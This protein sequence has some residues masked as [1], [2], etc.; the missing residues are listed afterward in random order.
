[1]V[2]IEGPDGAGKST[3]VKWL[4]EQ[5]DRSF[6]A[7]WNVPPRSRKQLER[8]LRAS[9]LLMKCG[10]KII[11]DRSPWVT[12]PIYGALK[13]GPYRTRTWSRYRAQL[14]SSQPIIVY[15]RPPKEVIKEHATTGSS[16]LDTPEYLNWIGDNIDTLI[17]LYDL[18]FESLQAFNYDWTKLDPASKSNLLQLIRNRGGER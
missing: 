16:P 4:G 11:Q 12:E 10:K 13:Q 2:I 5:V 7:R 6:V 3:L 15:C 14:K 8:N 17:Y 1:M 18:F 9:K